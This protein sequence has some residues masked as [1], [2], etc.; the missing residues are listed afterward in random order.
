MKSIYTDYETDKILK[1]KKEKDPEFNFSAWI[2]SKLISETENTNEDIVELS[3]QLEGAKIKEQEALSEQ[4]YI[5]ERI[6]KVQMKKAQEEM[7]AQIS[8]DK[9]NEMEE[10][11]AKRVE[12]MKKYKKKVSFEEQDGVK[13]DTRI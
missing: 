12:E 11:I 9:D 2:K 3:N 8:K 6:A 4:K 10:L 5:R 13:D 1:E 7:K